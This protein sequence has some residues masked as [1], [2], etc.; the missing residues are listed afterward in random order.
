MIPLDLPKVLPAKPIQPDSQES[1]LIV[2][3]GQFLIVTHI[4]Q[5]MCLSDSLQIFGQTIVAN[6]AVDVS[7]HIRYWTL[8]LLDLLKRSSL[9][10]NIVQSWSIHQVLH[11]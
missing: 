8:H 9:I 4:L 11:V 3:I 7:L 2:N 10:P 6:L 5:S 1:S